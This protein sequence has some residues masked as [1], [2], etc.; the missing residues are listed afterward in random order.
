MAISEE[1]GAKTGC[2]EQKQGSARG[3]CTHHH[4]MSGQNN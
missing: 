4:L 2:W 3:S 1:P